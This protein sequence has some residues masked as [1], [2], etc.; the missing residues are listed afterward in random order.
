MQVGFLAGL[1]ILV[2]IILAV[3][4]VAFHKLSHIHRKELPKPIKVQ[5]NLEDLRKLL[6]IKENNLKY[7]GKIGVKRR[8]P[9][10]DGGFC[11]DSALKELSIGKI[12]F[13]PRKEMK[14]GVKERVV[15]RLTQNLTEDLTKGLKGRGQPQIEEIKVG[16]FM[17]AKLTGDNFY[18]K[19][20]STEEQ[21]VG[22]EGF[23]EWSWHVTPL[24]SGIQELHLTVTVRVLIPGQDEQK[25]DW[26]VMDKRISVKVNPSYTIKRFIESYWQ[27]IAGTII[28]IVIAAIGI[29][30]KIRREER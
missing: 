19:S 15:V 24:K 17:M 26:D 11:V 5:R 2:T 9:L 12:L 30:K 1:I 22:E 8:I 6:E 29:R 28:T 13:N 25:I 21:V 16:T 27:W 18:I 7:R 20:L 23:T 10:G 14:V 4:V 3:I